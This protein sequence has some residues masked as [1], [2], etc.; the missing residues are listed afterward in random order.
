MVYKSK[1]VEQT[2]ILALK[3]AKL[4]VNTYIDNNLYNSIIYYI[5]NDTEYLY[6]VVQYGIN[7]GST[8][9]LLNGSVIDLGDLSIVGY[10]LVLGVQDSIDITN[11]DYIVLK[12]S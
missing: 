2:Y 9:N 5:E 11:R 10:N 12:I 8:L 1:N 7:H 6:G 3:L 4:I